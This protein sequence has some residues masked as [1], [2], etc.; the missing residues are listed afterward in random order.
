MEQGNKQGPGRSRPVWMVNR[1][2]AGT[3]GGGVGG[4]GVGVGGGPPGW[5]ID[6]TNSGEKRDG[7]RSNRDNSRAAG[8]WGKNVET[9]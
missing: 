9:L 4:R 6:E 8:S 5:M 7:M 3:S 1:I 2:L